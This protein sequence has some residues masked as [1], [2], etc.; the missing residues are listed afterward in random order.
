MVWPASFVVAR[1]YLDQLAR[2]KAVSANRIS[3]ARSAIQ[4][5]EHSSGKAQTSALDDVAK[6]AAELERDAAKA[7]PTDATR[8]RAFATTVRGAAAAMHQ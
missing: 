4:R 7:T 2:S 1:A 5:A 8:M 3:A 6:V